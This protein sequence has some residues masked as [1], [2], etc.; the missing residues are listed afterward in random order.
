LDFPTPPITSS[1]QLKDLQVWIGGQA[2]DLPVCPSDDLRAATFATLTFTQQKNGICNERIGHDRSGHLTLCPVLALVMQ[3]LALRHLFLYYCSTSARS[4]STLLL[5][6]YSVR[7]RC[8]DHT[9]TRSPYDAC[10]LLCTCSVQQGTV[11]LYFNY[12]TPLEASRV[13]NLV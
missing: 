11:K 12:T 10:V 7:V 1:S 4:T 2:L 3:V 13:N 8:V 5:L 9:G 6:N